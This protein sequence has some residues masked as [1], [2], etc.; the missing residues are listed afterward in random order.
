M[1]PRPIVIITTQYD[2]HT[3]AMIRLLGEMGQEP[4]RLNTDD[5]PQRSD[6]TLTL[7]GAGWKGHIRLPS[8]GRRIDIT[9]IRSIW[10]RRP[11]PFKLPKGMSE[12]EK[13]FARF[14][15]G[16]LFAGLWP[17]LQCY[18]ISVPSNIRQA[19]WKPEQLARAQRMGFET[20]KTLV[21]NEPATVRGFYE[22]CRSQGRDIVFKLMGDPSLGAL[23]ASGE[24]T[25]TTAKPKV[26]QTTL[27]TEKE[28]A[29]LDSVRLIPGFFQEY[30]PKRVELRVTIIGDEVFAA[31]ILSQEHE[32]TR[33]DWRSM[34]VIPTYRKAELPTDVAE[35][36]LAYVKSYGLNYS[37]MDLIHTPD[38][39][40][41]FLEN[42]PNGQ[43]LFVQERAPDIRL[44]EAMAACLIRGANA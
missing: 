20:P 40:Y 5:I 39:R 35:R 13:S 14:E 31:E 42:N 1:T 15:L 34:A 22:T 11:E 18:W 10:W 44:L 38:D 36:C 4:I 23:N 16:H 37:A 9:D 3:D 25:M 7:N 41:V 26:T 21:S 12:Q 32:A 29:L 2:S 43:F 33:V 24:L 17:L 28:L 6:V 27:I 30:I 8:T 19:G